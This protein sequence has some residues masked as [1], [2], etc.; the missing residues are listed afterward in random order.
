MSNTGW[1]KG[2]LQ[3]VAEARVALERAEEMLQVRRE[4]ALCVSNPLGDAGP[5]GKG[6]GNPAE[7][8]VVGLIQ[9]EEEYAAIYEWT[10]KALEEFDHLYK[11]NRPGLHGTLADG[12]DAAELKYR[13]GMTE[14]EVMDALH[15]SRSKL[16]SDQAAFVDYL[17]HIGYAR[18]MDPDIEMPY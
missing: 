2:W 4:R 17:D 14:P 16:Y 18:A 9:A 6:G 5:H 10:C 8:N 1:A 3:G 15:I 13:H 11:V 12:L 7:R